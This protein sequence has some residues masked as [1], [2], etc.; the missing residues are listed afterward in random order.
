MSERLQKF[1]AKAGVGSRRFC[2]ELIKSRKIKING[3]VAEIGVSVEITDVI[4]YE[5]NV[6]SYVKSD[7]KLLMLNKPEGVV[8][9]NKKEKNLP[10]V[11]DYLPKS[12]LNTRWISIG[13]LDINSSGLM[14]F[15]N[16]GT[17]ANFCMHP[18][19]MIDREYLVRARGE[20]TQEKKQKMLSGINIEGATYQLTDIVEGEKHSSNQWFSVCLM[21]GKNKEVRKIFNY[22]DLEISRLKR[23]R[24]GPIFLPSSLKKGSTI[25]LSNKEIDSLK[26]YG[27]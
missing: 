12:N 10:I 7:L 9:S 3:K 16:D 17:F 22:L 2:E 25:E 8:S 6:I 20:F 11:F 21:S 27:T 13:R 23:T 1:L 24:F 19:S 4:E 15:T 5:G 14:L 18:S 26:N